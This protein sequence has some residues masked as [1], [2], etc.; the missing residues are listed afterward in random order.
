MAPWQVHDLVRRGGLEL[1]LAGAW[2]TPSVP[3]RPSCN[4]ARRCVV[5]IP[6]LVIAGPTAGRL[7]WACVGCRRPADP[8]RSRRRAS[9]PTFTSWVKLFRTANPL[10]RR[11]HRPS[12]TASGC[13]S[14]PRF[15]ARSGPFRRRRLSC[16]RSSSSACT[17]APHDR[18]RWSRRPLRWISRAVDGCGATWRRS[19]GA[20][21]GRQPSRISS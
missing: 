16:S 19:I 17:M 13:S 5:P 18:R 7:S 20:S 21:M 1:V 12:M 14:R 11:R 4:G 15:G 6:R 3:D 2:R 9:N 8:H 10:D